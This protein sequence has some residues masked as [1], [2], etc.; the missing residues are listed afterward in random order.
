MKALDSVRPARGRGIRLRLLGACALWAAAACTGENIF[1]L[2]VGGGGGGLDGP[3]VEVSQPAEDAA[4][5][6]G[7]SIQVTAAITSENGVNQVTLSGSFE[8]GA[9]AY[10]Q[11]TVSL[12]G[13]TDTTISRFLQPAGTVTGPARIVVRANDVL[14]NSGADTVSVSVN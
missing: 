8:S 1:P 2:A 7:D 12:T 9:S 6:L 10:I 3:T 13:A 5:N 4:L 14:G 11:Q